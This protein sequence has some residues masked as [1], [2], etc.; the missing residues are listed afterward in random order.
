MLLVVIALIV[1]DFVTG[2]EGLRI[3]EDSRSAQIFAT[4]QARLSGELANQD[5]ALSWLTE[6]FESLIDRS[7]GGGAPAPAPDLGNLGGIEG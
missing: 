7:C 5:Q 6:R 4:A 1:H 2:A 3:V